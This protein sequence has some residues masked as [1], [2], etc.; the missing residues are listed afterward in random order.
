MLI[1][2]ANLINLLLIIAFLQLLLCIRILLRDADLLGEFD[3]P[4]TNGCMD[5]LF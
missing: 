3:H 5:L 4:V 2:W 1:R